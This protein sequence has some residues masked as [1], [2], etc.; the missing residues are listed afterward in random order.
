M[1][2]LL[3][4]FT[5]FLS[6]AQA[7]SLLENDLLLEKAKLESN[8]KNYHGYVENNL[9][10]LNKEKEKLEAK[11]KKLQI[12]QDY[13]KNFG[14]SRAYALAALHSRIESFSF[15]KKQGKT[16]KFYKC[17]KESLEE[18]N[19]LNHD[20][21]LRN[22]NPKLTKSEKD[23]VSDW[24]D[25]TGMTIDQVET[26]RKNLPDEIDKSLES[27][28]VLEK[29]YKNSLAQ[30]EYLKDSLKINEMKIDESKLLPANQHFMNC[31]SATPVIN[32]EEEVPYAGAKIQGPFHNVPRDNQD[33]LGTCYANTAKNLLV[34]VSGGDDV[35]SFLDLALLYKKSDGSLSTD[36]LDAGSSCSTLQEARKSGYCPQGF[37]PLET[38]ERNH[39]GEG[40]FRL[41]PYEYLATNVN[42]LRD[43]LTG[44][45]DYEKSK[46]SVSQ[47]IMAKA[48]QIISTLK[49]N[50]DIILPLPIVRHNIPEEW[51]L[52][53][54]HAI[55]KLE[56]VIPY[57]KFLEEHREAYK[58][59]YPV[60]IKAVLEGKSPDEIFELYRTNMKEFI[61]KYYL[62]N[63]LD[64]FK[65]VY[66]LKSKND[67]EDPD[68]RKKFKASI[69]FLKD[70]MNKNGMTDESFY[71]FC[72]SSGS[73]SLKFLSSMQPLIEKI[74][75]GKV[76]EDKLF[77]NDGKFKAAAEL[78]QLTVAPSCLNG[79][80]RKEVPAFSCDNGYNTVS[81]IKK[82]GKSKN[83]QIRMMRE[84]V[85]LG[86][87]QGYPLG[88]SYPTSA[89]SG[90][91]NTIVG[92]RFN[93]QSQSCEYLI[94]ES[95][96]GKSEWHK[97]EGIFDRIQGLTEVRRVK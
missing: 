83:D 88:N 69:S 31:N 66:K 17:L 85:V 75:Q 13:E 84:R 29:N 51:K 38:G 16:A 18:K 71:E 93:P 40:L 70:I 19:F 11:Q 26:N 89:G 25:K 35:A 82:S 39:A 50:P 80:N 77:D 76:N 61:S 74:R 57:D 60:Y 46:D 28:K 27:L 63:S 95:Q 67:F 14:D 86:L 33:G 20:Y 90:H 81:Q 9:Q 37:S 7:Q 79:E 21:C 55:K 23:E 52:K 94:R 64:E 12:L 22:H 3:P 15:F 78:M 96:N 65:R 49:G 34:G 6:V 73:D 2:L 5:L 87:I 59:F 30:V 53:E 36:G 10:R 91:I 62:L 48:S 54:A 92:L 68:L 72:S 44:L 97:E 56:G 4:V 58:K 41:G 1:K 47:E 43:F 32:L 24:N 8:L 42:L 45:S